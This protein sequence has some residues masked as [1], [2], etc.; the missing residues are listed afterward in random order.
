MKQFQNFID[1]RY[2]DPVGGQWLDSFDPYRAE[3]W[4]RIPRS[5]EAD[6][7]L[8]VAAAS[9]AFAEGEWPNLTASQRGRLLVRFAD[10]VEANAEALAEIETRDNGKLYA[11]MLGQLRYIPSFYR[12][13]GGMADKLEGNVVPI[14]KP[15]IFNFNQFEPLGVIAAIT[16][17]NSPLLLAT[18]KLAPLL[19]AGNTVVIKPSE[20]ASCST[21]AFARLFEEAGFPPGVV[22]VVTGLGGEVGAPLVCH[23]KVAKIAFTGGEPGARS[24]CEA[25]AKD[26]KPVLL[27]LGGKSANIVFE[28]AILDDAVNGA[29]SGIFAASGQSCLAGSR[30]L[31]H[32]SIHDE[33]VER[34]VNAVKTAVLGDP[35][36]PGTQIGP[37]TTRQQ[38][39]KVLDYIQVG[40]DDGATC[41]LGGKASERPEC[42]D[43]WFVEPTIFAN[44]TND[45]RIAQEEVFGP[46]LSIIRFKDE[47]DAVRIANDSVYGLAAGIWTQNIGRAMRMSKRL[48]AGTVWVNTYRALSYMSPFGG[49]KRSGVGRENG[50]H[51]MLEFVQQ[52][53]VWINTGTASVPNPFVMR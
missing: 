33:F 15:D 8:A 3:P 6:A 34:L 13:F 20:H 27:E 53:S 4:A 7:D 35:T 46:I 41:V 14:D 31:L 19:A 21:L 49:Y 26:F 18:F 17:W 44:V 28:D 16:P 1:N 39:E 42:G 2:V 32:D 29:I 52:K 50:A 48:Q 22:N 5:T 38:Y 23:P 24:I 12:Y 36:Q 30:L 11:E 45:M 25:V 10:V 37:V 40:L 47:E 9:R 43:G 51:A